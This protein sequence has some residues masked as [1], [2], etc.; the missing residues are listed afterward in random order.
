MKSLMLLSLTF[1]FISCGG[2]KQWVTD[3]QY[4][5]TDID[6]AK[7]ITTQFQVD[8]GDNVLPELYEPLPRNYGMF[9]TFHQKN[10]RWS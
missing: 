3:L 4:E 7:W 9:K 6:D 5:T 1:L 8:L 10:R 2:G